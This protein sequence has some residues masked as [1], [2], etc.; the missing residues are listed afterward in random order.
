MIRVLLNGTAYPEN[1]LSWQE[2]N[3][4]ISRSETFK[5]VIISQSLE[6]QFI[7]DACDYILDLD[8]D[9][10]I[11]AECT[12]EIQYHEQIAG[13]VTGFTGYLDF[14]TLKIDTKDVKKC[15]ISAYDSGFANKLLE[16]LD[17]EIPYDRNETIDGGTIT[18]KTDNGYKTVTIEGVEV[19]GSNI[20]STFDALKHSDDDGS[21]R[22]LILGIATENANNVHFKQVVTRYYGGSENPNGILPT[23]CYYYTDV[24]SNISFDYNIYY[25]FSSDLTTFP[26]EWELH[27][28]IYKVTFDDNL[29][30]DALD[31]IDEFDYYDV[32]TSTFTGSQTVDLQPNQ[33]I[34]FYV[35]HWAQNILTNQGSYFR[36]YN[37]EFNGMNLLKSTLSTDYS[38]LGD[39]TDCEMVPPFEAF[40]KIVNAITGDADSVDSPVLGKTENGYEEDGEASL[41]FLTNGKLIR[42]FPS[43]YEIDKAAQLSFKLKDIFENI[44]K[45]IPIGAG[46]VDGKL[47]V[48]KLENF[49]T[50]EVITTIDSDDM[51]IDS[52]EKSIDL[53]MYVNEI[54]VGSVYEQPEEVS[55]LEEY[56]SV[57][58]Y[59][60]PVLN[61]NK[62]DLLSN[63]IYAAYPFEFARRKPYSDQNTEDYKYDNNNFLFK[64]YRSG[65]DFVQHSA[66]DFT[67]ITGLDNITKYINLDI[68]P[69]R[70]LLR[71]GWV[72]NTGL[73]GYQSKNLTY[74]KSDI[75]TDL[76][77]Q[78]TGET[79]AVKECDNVLI[80]NLDTAKFTGRLV[81]FNAPVSF[82]L[83][84]LLKS[85]PYGLIKYYDP[86]YEDYGYGWIKE[87]SSSIIDKKTNFE[88]Y[89]TTGVSESGSFRMLQ[90]GNIRLLETDGYRLLE[91]S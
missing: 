44:N 58:K 3:E 1:Y 66:Q 51:E 36:V 14:K 83:F 59:A 53:T 74:N 31:I 39:P 70:N 12:I 89:E 77:T 72:I 2:R 5:G 64:V 20:K 26:N 65:S 21:A 90:D 15:T 28:R 82:Q 61:E 43:Y 81:K 50:N 63:Y 30:V 40:T 9:Y 38:E 32:I 79:E 87:V 80:S 37:D 4:L 45:I 67:L 54:N 48:D 55:G 25:R 69:K 73:R 49:Y 76:E 10:D 22:N 18:P 16:R 56:N 33:G 52:F 88:L 34:C 41:L 46:I 78:K 23:D 71:H 24:P 42:R 68:S 8:N 35:Y 47:Y 57:Q 29:N 75:V 6:L 7:K 84:N 11:A 13:W 85:N 62:Y 27:I 17:L 91:N 19:V 60:T 86:F